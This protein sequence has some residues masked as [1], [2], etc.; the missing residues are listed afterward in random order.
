MSPR[1]KADILRLE[2]KA[3]DCDKP[4]HDAWWTVLIVLDYLVLTPTLTLLLLDSSS[5][6]E[7]V[8]ARDLRIEQELL[9]RYLC[10]CSASAF[11]IL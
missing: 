7:V 11:C 9:R 6:E 3:D 2:I 1:T 10:A 5:H 8:F 4:I